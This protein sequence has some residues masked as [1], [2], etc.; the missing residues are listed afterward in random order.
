ML[1]AMRVLGLSETDEAIA[2]FHAEFFAGDEVD[3]AM[4]EEIDALRF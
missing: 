2:D 4:I 1:H 3:Y